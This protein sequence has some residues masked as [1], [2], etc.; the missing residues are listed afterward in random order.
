MNR[1]EF[2]VSLVG[3]AICAAVTRQA[4]AGT[5]PPLPVELKQS[6][7]EPVY[8]HCASLGEFTLRWNID[9][10]EIDVNFRHEPMTVYDRSEG[11]VRFVKDDR[12]RNTQ[13]TIAVRVSEMLVFSAKKSC[14]D[15]VDVCVDGPI[16]VIHVVT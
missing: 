10:G 13:T 2:G 6:F 7:G 8:N 9:G 12:E 16:G 1:R 14:V 5:I 15:I 11:I 4:D 3:A